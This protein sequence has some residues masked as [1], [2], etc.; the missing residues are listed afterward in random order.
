MARIEQE[1]NNACCRDERN[2]RRNWECAR[3]QESVSPRQRSSRLDGI[4][5]WTLDIARRGLSE[6][7]PSEDVS[8]ARGQSQSQNQTG[9]KNAENRENE[10]GG[11]HPF[12]LLVQ[13]VGF[14]LRQ[15][16]AGKEDAR[17]VERQAV[18]A[19]TESD[20]KDPKNH[21]GYGQWIGS[22]NG[23]DGKWGRRGEWRGYWRWFWFGKKI[24]EFGQQFPVRAA[25]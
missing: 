18:A 16:H 7:H 8:P 4:S 14:D 11:G 5:H 9:Q 23:R 19:T 12:S 17:N 10:T 13:R 24:L 15:C 22:R 25:L 1:Q 20:G 21:A 3:R 6:S 2:Y